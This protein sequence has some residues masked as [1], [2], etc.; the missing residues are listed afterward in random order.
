[1]TASISIVAFNPAW[2]RSNCWMPCCRPPTRR[3]A[4]ITSSRLPRMEPVIEALTSSSSPARMAK[5]VMMSSAA[6]PS[7]PLIRPLT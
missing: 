3:L 5:K 1:M 4:P 6:F 2:V 7:V